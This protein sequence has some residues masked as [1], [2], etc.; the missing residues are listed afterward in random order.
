MVCH[1]KHAPSTDSWS[2][3]HSSTH[4]YTRH[5]F[6]IHCGL[7]NLIK[8][9]FCPFSLFFLTFF[10]TLR[11]AYTY[12]YE[13]S[14]F[15]DFYGTKIYALSPNVIFYDFIFFGYFFLH[16]VLYLIKQF[17]GRSV[18]FHCLLF[19]IDIRKDVFYKIS[20]R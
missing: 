20:S 4:S 16:I 15:K 2:N 13:P 3:C 6:D 10:Q 17:I 1:G 19:I 12:P 8:G 7:Y 11:T 5:M 9:P 18:C 14:V